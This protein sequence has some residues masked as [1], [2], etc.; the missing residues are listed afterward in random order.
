[1][2]DDDYNPIHYTNASSLHI[3]YPRFH[4]LK[5]RK[6]KILNLPFRT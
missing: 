4:Y 6:E 3:L 2:N 1:M 5:K